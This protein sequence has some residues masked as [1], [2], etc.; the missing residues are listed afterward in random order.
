MKLI[1][2]NSKESKENFSLL[3]SDLNETQEKV[4]EVEFKEQLKNS[5]I[6]Q[7]MFYIRNKETQNFKVKG[8]GSVTILGME[9][10]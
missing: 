4:N 2:D 9:N 5:E 6:F 10:E 1:V 8:F 7:Q 3:S